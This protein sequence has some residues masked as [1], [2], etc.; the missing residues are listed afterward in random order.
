[1][2]DEAVNLALGLLPDIAVNT[3][4]MVAILEEDNGEE[5]DED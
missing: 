1:M 4:R 3:E 2:D 5:A